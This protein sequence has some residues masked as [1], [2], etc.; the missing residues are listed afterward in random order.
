[1]N[2]YRKIATVLVLLLA[3]GW[4][5]SP[6]EAAAQK[7]FV[8]AGLLSPPL[9]VATKEKIGQTCAAVALGG[10]QSVVATFINLA[11]YG[12]FEDRDWPKLEERYNLIVE[13]QPKSSYYW[14]VASWHLSYNAAVDYREREELPAAR[15]EALHKQYIQKGR[16]FLDR[17]IQ[18][19]PQDWTLYSSKGRNYAH[20]DKF[21]N[22][23]VAADA[24]RLAW[25]TGKGQRT[26]EARAWLYS[27]ARVPGKSQESLDLARELFRN[28]QNRVDSIRCLLFALE[29][30]A[31]GERTMEDLLAQCFEDHKTAA[32]MLRLY[33]QNNADQ[34]PQDGVMLAMQWLKEQGGKQ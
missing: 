15:R 20:K 2:F 22:F 32:E 30:Q 3:A 9:D 1:M 26:F 19:N 34:M 25:Q 7:N 28:P 18:N 5:K 21:P 6:W 11:A 12:S 8:A 16:D 23:A 14:D 31:K 27:L 17:G 33:H 29:W 10:M 4:L 13:L 24:Y